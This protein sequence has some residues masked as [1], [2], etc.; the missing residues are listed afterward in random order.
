MCSAACTYTV[1]AEGRGWSRGGA[2]EAREKF[3]WPQMRRSD[4]TLTSF[5]SGFPVRVAAFSRSIAKLSKL[6][7]RGQ[8]TYNAKVRNRRGETQAVHAQG[9]VHRPRRYDTAELL[10]PY[11]IPRASCHFAT[12]FH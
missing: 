11:N 2:P 12:A 9:D 6:S 10:R 3:R 5:A 7:N 8:R 1:T 4:R